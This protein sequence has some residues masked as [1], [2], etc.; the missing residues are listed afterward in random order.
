MQQQLMMKAINIYTYYKY[1]YLIVSYYYRRLAK[2]QNSPSIKYLLC[3][4]GN[5]FFQAFF[6]CFVSH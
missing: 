5:S 2:S 6:H 4:L 1:T 3:I